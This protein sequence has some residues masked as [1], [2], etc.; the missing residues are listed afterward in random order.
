LYLF[1]LHCRSHRFT[2]VSTRRKCETQLHADSSGPS[3]GR[4]H[5]LAHRLQCRLRW[6][7]EVLR[8]FWPRERMTSRAPSGE[9]ADVK[10]HPGQRPLQAIPTPSTTPAI[11][12]CLFNC[13]PPATHDRKQQNR[14]GW[15]VSRGSA[16]PM[17]S[18]I[19]SSPPSLARHIVAYSCPRI[20]A[21]LPL[22]NEAPGHRLGI[23]G[24]A[25]D[26]LNSILYASRPRQHP[27]PPLHG[28]TDGG[29]DTPEAVTA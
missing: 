10:P 17:V 23:N 14:V 20:C 9:E 1:H 6:P 3:D 7:G 24:L 16:S 21:V 28:N 11:P 5:D 29:A 8:S 4:R 27:A 22:A 18:S 19:P 15:S 12:L 2:L 13:V 25:V 26:P